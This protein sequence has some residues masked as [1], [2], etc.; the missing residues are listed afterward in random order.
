M[1]AD[2]CVHSRLPRRTFGSRLLKNTVAAVIVGVK[3]A[4]GPVK[5]SGA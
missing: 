5:V 2:T 1:R 4:D 3:L